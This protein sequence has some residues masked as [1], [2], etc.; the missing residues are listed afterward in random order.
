MSLD[1]HL[2][3]KP[4]CQFLRARG[5]LVHDPGLHC[6][7]DQAWIDRTLHV[8]PRFV[9]DKV[10][11]WIREGRGCRAAGA[12]EDLEMLLRRWN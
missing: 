9:A 2:A 12:V 5:L 1:T 10:R 4:V 7:R 3:A 6:G 11:V 8:L